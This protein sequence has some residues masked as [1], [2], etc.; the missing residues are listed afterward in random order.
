[1]AAAAAL[2]AGVANAQYTAEVL[3][4]PLVPAGNSYGTGAG[5]G[6]QVGHTNL[7]LAGPS[8]ALLWEGTAKSLIDLH[9]AGWDASYAMATDGNRQVGW[10]E[11]HTG[12]T[13]QFATMWNGSSKNWV[14]LHDP[15]YSETNALGVAG[16]MQVG[17]GFLQGG[18]TRAVMWRN[19]AESI[20]SLHPQ[21]FDR[22]WAWA[23][24]GANQVGFAQQTNAR[25][26]ALWAGSAESMIDLHPGGYVISEATGISDGQLVG[27]VGA[28]SGAFHAGLWHR[29]QTAFV[30]LNPAE[31][32]GSQAHATNGNVQVGEY[33]AFTGPVHAAAWA[34]SPGSMLDLHLALDHAYH[35]VGESSTAM[36]IDEFGNIVGWATH[37]P[38]GANHAVIWRPVPEPNPLIVLGLLALLSGIC[39]KLGLVR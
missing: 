2:C 21:G 37:L 15:F 3:H 13:G 25:H 8:H 34:G 16:D 1:M 32:F 9:P 28:Q 7:F 29:S 26:A 17:F 14:D 11:R 22:S 18:G 20:V 39:K 31:G 23:T 38:T 27:R 35:G 10:R 4:S 30:D 19:T 12:L 36:G 24:D 6:Q 5:G 33:A